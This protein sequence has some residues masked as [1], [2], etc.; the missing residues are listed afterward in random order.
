MLVDF[1]E[2][3]HIYMVDGEVALYSA[4]QLLA[5]HGLANDY[6]GVD[7]QVLE[8]KANYGTNVHKDIEHI[9]NEKD[10]EPTTDE[11]KLFK[12]WAKDK[13]SG[14]IAEQLLGLD[15]KGLTI[16]GSCDLLGF[17]KADTPI[18]AD[19]KTYY[20]MTSRTLRHIAWQL[21]LYDYM[22]RHSKEINGKKLKWF[23]A[24]TFLVLWYHKAEEKITLE[25]IEV[26]KIEDIE[27]EALLEAELK[28]EKYRP[29]ELVISDDLVLTLQEKEIELAKRELEVKKFKKEL[30]TYRTQLREIMEEQGILNWKSPNGVVS[31]SYVSGYTKN[32][33]DSKKLAKE[34]P[35]IYNAYLKP[36]SVSATVKV[37]VDEDK[38]EE[39]ENDKLLGM[40]H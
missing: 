20:Q 6:T 9:I 34:R 30:E 28:G 1:N 11:G 33:V 39:L 5:K 31:I 29:K 23:G 38:L 25:P 14:A 16:G 37:S 22:A 10:Y 2:S 19:H 12:E 13:L 36:S 7:K 32:S 27:I 4:T 24:K 18:I 35:D 40:E 26:D 3:K 15:Y 8:K 17:D 21:S